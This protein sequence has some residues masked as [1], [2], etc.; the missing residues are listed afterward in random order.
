LGT[1]KNKNKLA[2]A[3]M[4]AIAILLIIAVPFASAQTVSNSA[5]ANVATMKAQGFAYQEVNS[6]TVKYQANFAL[7]LQPAS[8][9]N[10]AI[11]GF[12]VAG[13][14]VVVN[15]V[16]YAIASGNGAVRTGRHIFVLKAQGTSPDGQAVTLKLEGRYF[17]I[18]EHL[19]VARIGA[20][21]QT[22]NGNYLLLMRA[23]VKV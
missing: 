23:A 9:S 1:L 11:K 5:T 10:G 7:T 4:A 21:L 12:D 14:T 8:T 20:K 22:D 13:G 6:Q 18:G 15:G 19:Y 3:A 16:S 2:L 17:W